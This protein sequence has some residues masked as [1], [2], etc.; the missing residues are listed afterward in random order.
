MNTSFLAG[1]DW[2]YRLSYQLPSFSAR[3]VPASILDHSGL[4]NCGIFMVD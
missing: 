1:E 2:P 4:F 3:R